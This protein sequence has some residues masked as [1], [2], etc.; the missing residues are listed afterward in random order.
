MFKKGIEGFA[1]YLG[2]DSLADIATARNGSA[3]ST[4]SAAS[5]VRS[6]R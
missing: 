4:S 6:R 2:V 1:Y 3:Y 5:R